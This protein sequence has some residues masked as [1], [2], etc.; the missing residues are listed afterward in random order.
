MT[1]LK[2]AFVAIILVLACSGA[3]FGPGLGMGMPNYDPKT[4]VILKGM[5]EDV[6]QLQGKHGWMGRT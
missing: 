6:Q 5:I 1:N 3:L 4:E 2:F